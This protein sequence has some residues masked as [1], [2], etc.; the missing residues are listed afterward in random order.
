MPEIKVN[1]TKGSTTVSN[2]STEVTSSN[3]SDL[4]KALKA[5]KEQ[6][7]SILTKLVEESKQTTQTRKH[8]END[9]TSGSDD[10]DEDGRATKK[11][12]NN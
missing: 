8:H 10:D 12:N 2:Q 5:A 1:I 11:P 6:T 7:N 4:L 9:D 3:L